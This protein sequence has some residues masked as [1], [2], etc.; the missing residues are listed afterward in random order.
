[1][2]KNQKLVPK[3]MKT[4]APTLDMLSMALAEEKQGRVELEIETSVPK[5][6]TPEVKVKTTKKTKKPTDDKPF[7]QLHLKL[8]EENMEY[9]RCIKALENISSTEAI[10]LIIEEDR[11]A[12]GESLSE[13]LNHLEKS[14]ASWRKTQ[15]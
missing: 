6:T 7:L 13:A 11:A 1:M 15:K 8:T 5:S 12:R 2:S 9:I 3:E 4:V 14:K 10:N